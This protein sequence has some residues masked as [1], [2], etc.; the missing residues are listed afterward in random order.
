MTKAYRLEHIS[1]SADR[2]KKNTGIESLGDRA[3]FSMEQGSLFQIC[4]DNML[5]CVNVCTAI[6]NAFGE[7]E[8]FRIDYANDAVCQIYQLTR[9]ELVGQYIWDM[10]PDMSAELFGDFCNIVETGTP[11]IKEV[12]YKN[13]LSSL[14]GKVYDVRGAKLGD[15]FI[16]TWRNV[17]EQRRTQ[18]ELSRMDKLNLVG[19]MAANIGHEVR[20]PMTTVR[21]YLQLFQHDSRFAARHEQIEMMIEELDRANS[22][23]TEFLSLAQNKARYIREECLSE[24]VGNM[25]PLLQAEADRLERKLEVNCQDT[26]TF[27]VSRNEIRQMVVNLV[28]NGLE[29][30]GTT[31]TVWLETYMEAEHAILS[32]RD[33]GPGIPVQI[34]E[35]LGIPFVSTKEKGLGLGLPVCY[36]IAHRHKA[37]LQIDTGN[38]GTTILVRFPIEKSCS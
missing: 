33:D 31:G 38:G 29:A 13:T 1:H 18:M 28:K 2:K 4:I 6:R 16:V 34:Y 5:D 3:A 32:V 30:V 36:R 15:G 37:E 24:L 14:H 12:V 9:K 21:G 19:E 20:N 27:C 25:I 26:V 8:N 7:I 11:M 10:L 22:I 17:T 23:I 35:K